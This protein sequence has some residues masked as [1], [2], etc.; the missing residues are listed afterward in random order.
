LSLGLISC[1]E[2]IAPELEEANNGGGGGPTGPGVNILKTF[3]VD[4]IKDQPNDS[5]VMH[6][7]NHVGTEKCKI[8]AISLDAD[9]PVYQDCVIDIEEL[10]LYHDGFKVDISVT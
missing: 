6:K 4:V 1:T 10:D 3:S 2:S 9:S 5:V 7:A 8:E